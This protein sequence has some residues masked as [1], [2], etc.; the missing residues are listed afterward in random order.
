M[1]SNPCTIECVHV[2][3]ECVLVLVTYRSLIIFA[4]AGVMQNRSYV[5]LFTQSALILTTYPPSHTIDM[6]F[7]GSALCCVCKRFCSTRPKTACPVCGLHCHDKCRQ[8]VCCHPCKNCWRK[9]LQERSCLSKKFTRYARSLII[10]DQFYNFIQ[11][12]HLSL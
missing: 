10:S 12:F 8:S 2:M 11:V 4:Q 7:R 1:H 3:I 6:S 9:V 5:C